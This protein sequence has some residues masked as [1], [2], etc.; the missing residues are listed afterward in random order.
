MRVATRVRAFGPGERA[1]LELHYR[2]GLGDAEIARA[3]GLSAVAVA[4]LRA[5]LLQEL[6]AQASGSPASV[7]AALRAPL[8]HERG[9]EDPD[10]RPERAEVGT[11]PLAT[12]YRPRRLSRAV[13]LALTPVRRGAYLELVRGGP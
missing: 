7:A 2:R 5:T 12:E 11:A 6:A 4:G 8:V 3:T 1:L 10:P 13:V 9:G